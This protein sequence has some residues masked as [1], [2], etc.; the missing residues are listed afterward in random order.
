MGTQ[1]IVVS[2]LA[3]G[4]LAATARSQEP[5]P[6]PGGDEAQSQDEASPATEAA[7]NDPAAAASIDYF[8]QEL[9]PYGQWVAHEGAG[10]VWVPKVPPGWRPYTTGHWTYTDQGWAWVA[11]EPW[12][13]AAFHYGRWAYDQ[14]LGWNWAPGNVW[15]PAWVAWRQGGGY[16]GW[17]PLPP[18]AGF[19]AEVGG[20]GLGTAADAISAGFFT[21]V[22][23]Q[24]LLA[25]NATTVILPSVRNVT[26]VSRAVNV[27]RYAVLGHRV[28]NA[29]VDVHRIERVTG[30][31]VPRLRVEEMTTRA[32]RGRGAFYQPPVVTRAAGAT[33][34]E[35]GRAFA[36]RAA[37]QP[38]RYAPGSTS[39]GAGY[40]A[41]GS[42]V[43]PEP[44]R[45]PGYNTPG[46][47]T[48]QT[49]PD[50]RSSYAP[51][52]NSHPT[53]QTVPDRR[54]SYARPSPNRPL[55]YQ[56]SPDRRSSYSRPQVAPVQPSQ[57][58][59]TAPARA[60]PRAQ[61]KPQQQRPTEKS[62]HRPPA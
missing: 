31:P 61:E 14:G 5:P 40:P 11:D 22:A 25:P 26:I 8:H 12:G 28:I 46:R 7:T 23:E 55:P 38:R 18:S 54:P 60:Q 43:S 37:V 32:G 56:T 9:A 30:R 58:S 10:E 44:R 45:T 13:W 16:L 50:R 39:A 27:T 4:L 51:P 52:N 19:S 2:L 15:A 33:R 57:S 62:R 24:N 41:A 47:P 3:M 17:A 53:Y 6:Y 21:F 1:K 35:F 42:R 59:R 49:S 36:S 29:G 20:V 48:Y 34:A